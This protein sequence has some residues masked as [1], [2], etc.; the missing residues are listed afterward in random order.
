MSSPNWTPT[1]DDTPFLR[2]GGEEAIRRLSEHFYDHMSEHETALARLHPCDEQGRVDRESRERFALFLIG[3]LGGP[4]EYMRVRGHPRLRM[5]HAPFPVDVAMRDAW[6][7]SMTAAMDQAGVQGEVRTILESRFA[8]MADFL[9]N[10]P[11]TE[12]SQG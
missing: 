2:L 7:R 9:R 4:Q 1:P 6:M 10:V 5:R 8:A 11:E 3:W 12:P